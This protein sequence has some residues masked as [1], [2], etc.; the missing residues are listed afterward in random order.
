MLHRKTRVKGQIQHSSDVALQGPLCEKPADG[1]SEA[2]SSG[3]TGP[4][5]L[6]PSEQC[7][8]AQRPVRAETLQTDNRRRGGAEEGRREKEQTC[9]SSLKEEV[10]ANTQRDRL[11]TEPDGT[12]THTRV[13]KRERERE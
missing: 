1:S 12:I 11:E 3:P 5:A 9:F 6:L 2:R 13:S 4:P 8:A 10:I 7:Q